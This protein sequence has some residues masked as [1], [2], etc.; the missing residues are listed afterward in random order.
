LVIQMA[1]QL[2]ALDQPFGEWAKPDMEQSISTRFEE[3]VRRYGT[4]PAVCGERGILTYLELNRLANR[5]ARAIL[6]CSGATAS[7]VALYLSH[8]VM[9]PAATL[10]VLKTGRFYIPLGLGHP[11]ERNAFILTDSGAE[12]LLT[13]Q[14]N[15]SAAQ[16]LAARAGRVV[17]VLNIEAANTFPETNLAIKP[18]AHDL[19]CVI[20]TSGSTGRPKG[21]C[22]VH[23]NI[24]HGTAWYTNQARIGPQDRMSLLH[25]LSAIGGATALYAALLNGA[26]I[27]PC[28]VREVGLRGLARWLDR[29]RISC[30]HAVPTLFRRLC[31]NFGR[32][33]LDSVRIVRLGGEAITLSDW[34][35]WREHFPEHCQLLVGLGST[36]TLNFRQTVYDYQ[37]ELVDDVLAVG[38]PVPDMEVLLVDEDGKSVGAG[39]VGEIVV[40]SEYL[41]PGYWQ[42]PDLNERVLSADPLDGRGRLFRTGDLGRFGA[43]GKLFHV[44]RSDS[45]VKV[46]GNRVETAEVEEALRRITP[47][48]EAAVIPSPQSSKSTRLVAFAAV[49]GE[50]PPSRGELRASLQELLPNYMIPS[51][52]NFVEELPLLPEGKLDRRALRERTTAHYNSEECVEPQNPIEE[53]LVEIW[54]RAL[55]ITG[56]SIHDNLF[57]MG[58]DSLTAVEILTEVGEVFQRQLPLSVIHEANTV[59]QLSRCLLDSGW[60]PPESGQLVVNPKGKLSPVFGICGAFGHALR[61]MV[62]GNALG[63][64]RPFHGLQPP[65][66]DWGRAGCLTI[67][68]MAAHYVAQIRRIQPHGPYHIIGTSFGGVIVFEMAIQLQQ[69]GETVGL[70]AMVDTNPPNCLLPEGIDFGKRIEWWTGIET[71]EPLLQM[72]IRVAKTHRKALDEYV[73]RDRYRGTITYF[74][75]EPHIASV[76]HDRRSLW[77]GFASEG[78]LI[79]KVPGRHGTFHQEP[80]F[81]AVV[82]G[83]RECL[84]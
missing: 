41:F 81:S 32:R 77:G 84:R 45:Q 35:M 42:R 2:S 60:R 4:R 36:E 1:R 10:G 59:E 3:Q 11:E 76:E 72:G 64:D 71:R 49:G 18:S 55:G 34:L 19:S 7:G 47:I 83:L 27:C 51:E 82:E 65:G 79:F 58:G 23:R 29:E 80:Q 53:T 26:A 75:C 37:T 22:Q 61:L 8:D 25:S 31:R 33:Q 78:M 24:L 20:Y 52:I 16:A 15:I 43:D 5:I 21:V 67:D 50:T 17:R 39:E 14:R 62:I 28:D 66:M 38:D 63:P 57:N 73:L 69:A 56:I 30:L 40:R 54:Q 6:D 48:H 46:D 44:G 12:I 74:W 70:L 13:D 9:L 68:A